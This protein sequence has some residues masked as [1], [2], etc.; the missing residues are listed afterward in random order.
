MPSA[1]AGTRTILGRRLLFCHQ[2]RL[3]RLVEETVEALR[4]GEA[5]HGV[6]WTRI[7]DRIVGVFISAV[8]DEGG[9]YLGAVEVVEDFTKAPKETEEVLKRVVVL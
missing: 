1:F 9:R 8:R 6:Y 3:E 7:G 2:P 4:R 5:D